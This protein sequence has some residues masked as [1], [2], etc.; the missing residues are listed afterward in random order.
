MIGEC[1]VDGCDRPVHTRG[2]CA[3][4][5]S[6][7]KRH[8]SPLGGKPARRDAPTTLNEVL[9]LREGGASPHE[10]TAALE[11]NPLSLERLMHRVGRPDLAAIFQA[12]ANWATRKISA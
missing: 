7:W 5:Y 9:W 10:I 12:E 2:W 1:D 11:M 3:A 8:G 4:H 6:R